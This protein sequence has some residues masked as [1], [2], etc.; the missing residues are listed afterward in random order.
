M[1]TSTSAMNG[2]PVVRLWVAYNPI[3]YSATLEYISMRLILPVY[4]FSAFLC[5]GCT[6]SS[7]ETPA[8]TFPE[9]RVNAT[10]GSHT[11]LTHDQGKGTAPATTSA[12][13]TRSSGSIL[14]ALAMGRNANYTA[15]TDN[16]DNRWRQVG[17]RNMYANGP[18]Y[19][20]VWSSV[21]TNGGNNHTLS[22]DKPSDPVDEISLAFVEIANARVI[23]DHTYRYPKAEEVITPG[24]VKTDGPATLIAIWGGDGSALTHTAIPS[25]G[26]KVIESYLNLG[27]TSGVQVAIAYKEVMKAGT[28]SMSWQSTPA[29]GAACYLIAVE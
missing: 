29:Q 11:L 1:Q 26:F 22:A 21:G 12:V 3:L 18:F 4:V 16:Y 13:T 5:G 27:P 15:P 8:K 17:G 2:G 24:S 20:A 7:L 19:T 28:Y 9:G 10:L 23:K 6:D 14:F 25:D